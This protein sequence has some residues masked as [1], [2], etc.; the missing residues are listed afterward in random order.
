MV[1]VQRAFARIHPIPAAEV[2]RL[3]QGAHVAELKR[4]AILFRQG[5]PADW[6]GIVI[7]GL[8]RLYCIREGRS[9]N[10]GFE[11]EG[12]FIG[13]YAAY[14]QQLPT[15]HSEETLEPSRVISFSR[16][17]LGRMMTE[18]EHWRELA[19][20]GAEVELVRKLG[21]EVDQRTR[22]PAERYAAL[23]DGRSPLLQRVPL[24]HLASYLGVTPETL[25]RIRARRATRARS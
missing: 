17:L 13:D 14:M 25:S 12:G 2:A 16:E 7:R 1:S 10:L 9:V 6:L 3:V 8:V 5:Q 23:V 21:K 11:I 4:G 18:G 22:T 24:Y 20:R 15:S 19:R